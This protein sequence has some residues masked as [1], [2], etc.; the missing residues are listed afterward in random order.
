MILFSFLI[1]V[2]AAVALL[3]LAYIA[4]VLLVRVVAFAVMLFKVLTGRVTREQLVEAAAKRKEEKEREAE[5]K[6]LRKLW[7]DLSYT[8]PPCMENS[9]VD[10]QVH[11][12][13]NN[14]CSNIEDIAQGK[15]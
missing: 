6:R 13:I 9:G 12:D 7:N 1:G 3:L 5:E 8:P 2:L 10:F 11:I 15:C 14:S 4:V